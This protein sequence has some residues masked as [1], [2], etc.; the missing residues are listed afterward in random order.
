MESV[1]Y[2]NSTPRDK[3]VIFKLGDQS[4]V[5]RIVKPKEKIK[6]NRSVKFKLVKTITVGE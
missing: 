2:E 4:I 3:L 5:E 1:F 6:L